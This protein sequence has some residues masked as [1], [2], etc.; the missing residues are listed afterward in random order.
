MNTYSIVIQGPIA[1]ETARMLRKYRD[2]HC[3][4]V[5][6]WENE[7]A[8]DTIRQLACAVVSSG[9]IQGEIPMPP[10]PLRQ[11]GKVYNNSNIY[12]QAVTALQGCEH[13]CAK[14]GA[15]THILKLRSDEV[16]NDVQKL[17]KTLDESPEKIVTSNVTFRPDAFCAYHA[18]DH[19]IGARRE[20]H[21]DAWKRVIEY[22]RDSEV[23]LRSSSPN[24]RPIYR[25]SWPDVHRDDDVVAEVVITQCFLHAKDVEFDRS[26]D[27]KS[28]MREHY[29][30]V[31]M[32]ALGMRVKQKTLQ[33]PLPR[34]TSLDD[35]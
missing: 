26:S 14:H 9:L 5:S 4:V 13:V 10:K 15:P 28:V 7:P 16:V 29:A 23:A 11:H 20:W 17:L 30:V 24:L 19:V 31:P 8:D 12:A 22:C 21:V 2:S 6:N 35:L 1:L 27:S 32:E 25:G 34:I 33:C 18:D 3:I